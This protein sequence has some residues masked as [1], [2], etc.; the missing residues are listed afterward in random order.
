MKTF[1]KLLM[2]LALSF[3]AESAFAKIIYVNLANVAAPVKD[4]TTWSTAYVSLQ[5]AL[6]DATLVAGDQIWV[7]KGVYYPSVK[8]DPAGTDRDR[9]FVLK[10]GVKIYGGF[11]GSGT[12][13]GISDRIDIRSVNETVLSGDFQNNDVVALDVNGTIESITG[14]TENAYHVVVSY[15]LTAATVLDGFTIK[16]GNADGTGTVTI[17]TDY[18]FLGNSGGGIYARSSSATLNN[19]VIKHNH[20]LLNGAGIYINTGRKIES[21]K[22]GEDI[23][24]SSSLVEHN[25]GSVVG[26]SFTG[27]AGGGIAVAGTSGYV[28][29]ASFSNLTFNGN[30]GGGLAG[31]LRVFSNLNAEVSNCTFTKNKSRHGGAVYVQS[32]SSTPLK[33][34]GSTFNEN[35][36]ANGGAIEGNNGTNLDILNT[37]FSG[38]TGTSGGG[39]YILGTTGSSLSRLTVSGGTFTGNKATTGGA[40]RASQAVEIEV[41]GAG[42]TENIT[43]GT[44]GAVDLL[45][46]ADHIINTT[47]ANAIFS[48]NEATEGGAVR[49]STSS[50]LTLKNTDFIENKGSA[51]GGAVFMT[52]TA[53]NPSTANITG[54]LFRGNTANPT[55]GTIYGGAVYKLANSTLGIMGAKFIENVGRSS[56][57]AVYIAGKTATVD[58]C[59]FYK[60][61]S[62]G[63]GGSITLASSTATTITGCTFYDNQATGIGGA[64]RV[65]GGTIK[66]YNSIIYANTS[67][68]SVHDISNAGTL[69]VNY[70]ITQAYGTDGVNGVKVGAVPLFLSTTY[71]NS[72]FLKLVPVTNNPAINAGDNGLVPKIFNNDIPPVDITLTTATDLAGAMR[73][74][75]TVDL[76]AYENHTVL[77]VKLTDFSV[78]SKV[79]AVLV[80]W[81]TET[82]TNNDYFLLERSTD[83][84]T[85]GLLTKTYSKGNG[86][87]YNYT[88]YSPINGVNYYRLTQI[89]KDGTK[90]TFDPIAINYS[91]SNQKEP[92][93][94]PNPVIAGKVTVN[95]AGKKFNKVEVFSTSGQLLHSQEIKH[96]DIEKTINIGAYASGLYLIK[97]TGDGEV[98]LKKILK[99]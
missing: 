29:K 2:L 69:D 10:E 48:R 53:A 66:I 59:L 97:L 23:T 44:G 88:D 89:D 67:T 85:Y 6:D 40:I 3:L 39:I 76:G 78:K 9:T 12:E 34:I 96:T 63:T 61:S 65:A 84:V 13:T 64:V 81:Q 91:L 50:N 52:G 86:A 79:N 90:V 57:G 15:N 58:N 77:P 24:I 73:F 62:P 21:P 45:G 1:T 27:S 51:G 99:H 18:D 71:G 14:N 95:F 74:N 70:T 43:T 32:N 5:D 31:A 7:A 54:G 92:N 35:Y 98:V 36:G 11:S 94:Y 56:G 72:D 28:Y 49:I 25:L 41:D 60:N 93:V 55:S 19:L 82:E 4:G 68:A 37:N 46:T 83:G 80:N 47:I 30:W 33:I 87:T 38:N 22:S 42:F 20:A 26:T 8:L 75:G 16:G 17:D